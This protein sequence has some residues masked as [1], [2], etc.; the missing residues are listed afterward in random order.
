MP[1]DM[2]VVRTMW[3]GLLSVWS[4]G[5]FS[6]SPFFG[7]TRL[8]ATGSRRSPELIVSGPLIQAVNRV[9]NGELCTCGLRWRVLNRL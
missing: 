9:V 2:Q 3:N 8:N 7:R 5:H 4:G 6:L 1:F